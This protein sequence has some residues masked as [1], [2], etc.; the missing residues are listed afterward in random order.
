MVS[1]IAPFLQLQDMVEF[2]DRCSI[3]IQHALLAKIG[4]TYRLKLCWD[5]MVSVPFASAPVQYKQHYF[6]QLFRGCTDTHIALNSFENTEQHCE[7]VERNHLRNQGAPS[8]L[9]PWVIWGLGV[10]DCRH[11][12]G[13]IS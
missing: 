12:N 4:R 9:E 7:C 2:L 1:W 6:Q 5:E 10:E 11:T 8:Q 3:Y 13:R